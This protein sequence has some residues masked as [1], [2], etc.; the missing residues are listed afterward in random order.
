MA[1]TAGKGVPVRGTV[2]GH[3]QPS[4]FATA[5]TAQA[6]GIIYAAIAFFA[7]GTVDYVDSNGNSVPVTWVKG[8]VYPVPGYGVTTGGNTTL[9][10]S[11]FALLQ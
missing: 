5:A 7:D 4:L 8:S 3:H 10:S 9:T 11:Q 2:Q 6:T 1:G